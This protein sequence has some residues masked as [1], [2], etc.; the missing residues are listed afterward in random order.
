MN[1]IFE[2]HKQLNMKKVIIVI[3]IILFIILAIIVFSTFNKKAE[4]KNI[5]QA[6]PNSIFISNDNSIS[7]ELPKKYEFLQYKPVQD[8]ILELR[9][10]NNID[11]FISKKDLVTNRNLSD[12]VSADRR[13]YVEKFKSCSNLSDIADLVINN[14]YQAY[15]YSFHYLDNKTKTSYYL[16]IIWFE[17]QNG[18]YI[19]DIEFPLDSLETNSSLISEIISN[20]KIM[21]Q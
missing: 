14:K 15:T 9:T 13:S 2:F 5:N 11:I 8:Y 16:Q 19:L 12:I 18:Y 4:E 17:T 6:N 1:E 20:L 10:V 3:A 21:E 7:I